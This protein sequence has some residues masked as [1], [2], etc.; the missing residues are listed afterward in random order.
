MEKK[1][2]R[3]QSVFGRGLY[4]RILIWT[5]ISMIIVSF[6]LF[7]TGD[8]I[9]ADAG[10]RFTQPSTAPS[11]GKAA[12]AQPT[13]IG[14][15][16]GGP[17]LVIVDKEKE[18]KEKEAK[19]KEAKEKG[20]AKPE[21][22]KEGEKAEPS[23]DKKPADEEKKPEEGGN[24]DGDKTTEQDKGKDGQQKQVPVDDKDE[25][26]AEEDAE[27]QKKW[28]EDLKKMPWLKFPP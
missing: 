16:D 19:E 9:V 23:Q 8:G 26:S 5:V 21:E 18:A 1:A 4:R 17:V 20:D 2:A 22:K 24:K 10:S 27:A 15:E 11:T 12:P 13:I 3:G 7:K 28:D 14:N 25:L 6:A